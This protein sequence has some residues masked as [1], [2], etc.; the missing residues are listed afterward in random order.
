MNPLK[1]GLFLLSIV[2]FGLASIFAWPKQNNA[3][4]A[5]S[6]ALGW[7]GGATLSAAL[8]VP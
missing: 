4:G 3:P 5:Y 6:Y 7:A 2:L 1:M 8:A